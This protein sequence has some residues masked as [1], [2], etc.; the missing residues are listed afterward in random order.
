MPGDDK[1]LNACAKAVTATRVRDDGRP[2]AGVF[3]C[4]CMGFKSLDDLGLGRVCA[5]CGHLRINHY[6]KDPDKAGS[7][8]GHARVRVDGGR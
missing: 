1:P 3:G 4:D 7:L 6:F 5:Q 8:A 2:Y